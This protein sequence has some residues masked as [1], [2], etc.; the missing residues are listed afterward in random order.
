[1]KRIFPLILISICISFIFS[2]CSG[3]RQERKTLTLFV[4]ASLTDV[5]QEVTAEFEKNHSVE[6]I[7]N[8]AG[9]GALARQLLAS[10]KA[11]LYLSANQRW[12]NEVEKGGLLADGT[13]RTLLSNTLVLI[14]N[15]NSTWELNQPTAF[16]QLPFKFLAIGDPDSVPA[17]KYAKT[18]LESLKAENGNTLWSE[19]QGR[20]SPAPDVRAALAQVEG[21]ANVIGIV[22][23]T[24][25]ISSDGKVRPL[26]KVP[27]KDGPKIEYS[28]AILKAAAEPDLS[29]EFLNF[30]SS[31][32]AQEIFQKYGF[33]TFGRAE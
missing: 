3:D 23:G 20:I 25:F 32:K 7:Y 22:Y 14:A 26:Y 8:F 19:V 5:I 15:K 16:A 10:P 28:A 24:D 12:M 1:M 9:S 29:V 17:G 27:V 2:A 30:L 31:P 21:S 13:R 6:F 33:M 4:A 18:W 11:D